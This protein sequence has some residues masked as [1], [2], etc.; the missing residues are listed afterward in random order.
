MLLVSFEHFLLMSPCSLRKTVEGTR[1]D[2]LSDQSG[3]SDT[4]HRMKRRYFP[5]WFITPTSNFGAVSQCRKNLCKW[6]L[7]TFLVLVSALGRHVNTFL[8]ISYS[9]WTDWFF[10]IRVCWSGNVDKGKRKWNKKFSIGRIEADRWGIHS[11]LSLQS[12]SLRS[13]VSMIMVRC[14]CFEGLLAALF[15]MT[16]AIGL[17]VFLWQLYVGYC[18][19][20]WLP[21]SIISLSSVLISQ[22]MF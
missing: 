16:L 20:L 22:S 14:S 10:A 3:Q 5:P 19:W 2:V 21:S 6:S 7:I 17:C 9:L 11:A 18:G 12:F 8:C 13:F 15:S 1:P 4:T